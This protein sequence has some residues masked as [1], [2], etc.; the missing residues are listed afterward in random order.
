M[1]RFWLFRRREDNRE[2][3]SA[4]GETCSTRQ[5]DDGI[6]VLADSADMEEI[7]GAQ[8]R[9]VDGVLCGCRISCRRV[10]RFS[11][12]TIRISRAA[13]CP[14]APHSTA[15]VRSVDGTWHLPFVYDIERKL[16]PCL[17]CDVRSRYL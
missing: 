6:S 16:D 1:S 2:K 3:A 11:L 10:C 9:R 15:Q 7:P 13:K 4:A 14:A 5:S 12:H 17:C 8:S